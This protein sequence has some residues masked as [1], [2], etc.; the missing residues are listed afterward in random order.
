VRRQLDEPPA[1][2]PSLLKNDHPP[3]KNATDAQEDV[4]TH[5][6]FPVEFARA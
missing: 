5:T 2:T 6:A 3:M 4:T 1:T